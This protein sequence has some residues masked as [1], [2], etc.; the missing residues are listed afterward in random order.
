MK[1]LL[2]LALCTLMF[3]GCSMNAS[4]LGENTSIISTPAFEGMSRNDEAFGYLAKQIRLNHTFTMEEG[5][6][7]TALEGALL[8]EFD[9]LREITT[10]A[11]AVPYYEYIASYNRI[12]RNVH[13][14]KNILNEHIALYPKSTQI[15]YYM[16]IDNITLLFNG[17]NH[18]IALAKEDIDSKS[19]DKL[20]GQF[21]N[22]YGAVKPLISTAVLL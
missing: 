4:S 9:Y 13:K 19:V 7:L 8:N 12:K 11:G 2:L 16:T 3:S 20:L 6:T 17:M 18:S 22:L 5:R 14:M 10:V 15:I 21:T 1:K